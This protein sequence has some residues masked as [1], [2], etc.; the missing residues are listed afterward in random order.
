M[1]GGCFR[2]GCDRGDVAATAKIFVERARDGLVDRER[3]QEG[4]GVE[5]GGGRDHHLHS[6]RFRF[7]DKYRRVIGK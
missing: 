5:Q 3:R 7:T 2:D 1:C 4:V 6:S